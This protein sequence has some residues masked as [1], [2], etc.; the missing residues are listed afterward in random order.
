M[1]KKRIWS[2]S[3][4]GVYHC[5]K[6]K[7]T[8]GLQATYLGYTVKT[9]SI[10]FPLRTVALKLFLKKNKVYFKFG[11]LQRRVRK[12]IHLQTEHFWSSNSD[13]NTIASKKQLKN[14]IRYRMETISLLLCS[15]SYIVALTACLVKRSEAPRRFVYPSS[16]D[17]KESVILTEKGT[18]NDLKFAFVPFAIFQADRMRTNNIS[19]NEILGES[20]GRQK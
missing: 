16:S 13:L 18:C 7:W 19:N 11:F 4:W 17:R 6:A 14:E 1:S 2:S 9:H 10:P 5:P 8:V 3:A 15:R 20:F 12:D